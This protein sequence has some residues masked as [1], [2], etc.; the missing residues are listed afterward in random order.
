MRPNAKI[1]HIDIDPAEIGKN[2]P[3]R[4]AHRGRLQD[5]L[6]VPRR[7]VKP[8]RHDEWLAQIDEWK[9]EYPLTYD[10]RDGEIKP[11]AVIEQLYE[12]TGG[13]AIMH[14]RRGPAPDVA[15][16]VLQVPRAPAVHLLRRPGHHGL[17]LPRRHRREVG[18]PR[19]DGLAIAG[20]GG[21]QMNIQELATVAELQH[22][23]QDGHPQQ[24]VPG[25]GAPVAGVLLRP[26]LLATAAWAIPDFVKIAEGYGV[27][28]MRVDRPEELRADAGGGRGDRG[29]VVMDVQV[30]QEE[31]CFPMVPAGGVRQRR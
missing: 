19:Q 26:P 27:R 15:G 11:Q 10:Q 16:A 8:K 9:Q 22:P 28:G 7:K 2:V 21:F 25:H 1:I 31:N 3:R 17:R 13:E 14:R 5:V 30:A 29:P 18:P 12:V 4:R 23:R 24:P 6:S 20:D